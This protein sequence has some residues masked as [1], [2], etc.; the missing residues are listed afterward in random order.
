[1]GV[2]IPFTDV[3]GGREDGGPTM[4][5]GVPLN[6]RPPRKAYDVRMGG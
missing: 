4:M 1:M 3:G 5:T 2:M 6:L